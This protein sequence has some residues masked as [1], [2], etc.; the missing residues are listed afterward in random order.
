MAVFTSSTLAVL[1]TSVVTF[2]MKKAQLSK[3]S[4]DFRMIILV[5]LHPTVD[6]KGLT[7]DVI[8][9]W[10]SQEGNGIGNVLWFGEP[11]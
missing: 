1:I 7:G 10:T 8:R 2:S 9:I 4:L 3:N 11:L 5:E 6:F